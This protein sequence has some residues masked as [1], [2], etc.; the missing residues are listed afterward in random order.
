MFVYENISLFAFVLPVYQ[1][2]YYTVQQLTFSR[3]QATRFYNGLLLLCMLFLLIINASLHLGGSGWVPTVMQMLF[4]PLLL[5]IFPLFFLSLYSRNEIKQST[6]LVFRILLF[7][8]PAL[9]LL[10]GA[11][12]YGL[13]DGFQQQAPPLLSS[14]N[15]TIPGFS[16]NVRV[17]V[18]CF[19]FTLLLAVQAI[20]VFARLHSALQSEWQHMRLDIRLMAWQ[21][22]LW[23]YGVFISLLLFGFTLALGV[24]FWEMQNLVNMVIFL[25]NPYQGSRGCV[26][27][28]PRMRI[29]GY[30]R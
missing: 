19:L 13:F 25:L 23:V 4:H 15:H 8:P 5:G 21:K 29:R 26:A 24:L 11:L 16:L 2:L 1:L 3:K 6:P 12:F 27:I 9:F 14:C 20:L 22:P 30:S 7:A 18:Y 10:A 28:L 17:L